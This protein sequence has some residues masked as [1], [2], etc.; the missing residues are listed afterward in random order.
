[1]RHWSQIAFLAC[2]LSVGV[3]GCFNTQCNE[4]AETE[5]ECGGAEPS[6]AEIDSC[7]SILSLDQQNACLAC[8]DN[9]GANRCAALRGT[10]AELCDFYR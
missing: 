7:K 1:M 2:S 3:T 5:V 9:A 6:D 8:L 4:L 10:C